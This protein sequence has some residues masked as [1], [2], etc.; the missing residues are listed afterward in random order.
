M[1]PANVQGIVGLTSN[2]H[3]MNMKSNSTSAEYSLH[4]R[5]ASDLSG[6][7][8]INKFK[9]RLIK[10]KIFQFGEVFHSVFA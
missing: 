3:L 9:P 1:E 5:P 10:H 6:N 8:I 4:K 2:D 7:L